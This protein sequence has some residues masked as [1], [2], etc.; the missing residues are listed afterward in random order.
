M[1]VNNYVTRVIEDPAG[2]AQDHW[3]SLL[4]ACNQHGQSAN[5]TL[6]PFVRHAYLAA[7]HSSASAVTQTGWQAYFVSLWDTSQA[8]EQL[9]GVCPM[10]IKAHSYGEYVFDFAWARAY[11][12][13]GLAYYPKAVIAPPFTP[14]PGPRLIAATQANKTALLAA[15][16]A[17]CKDLGVS[18]MH[19]LFID[20][21][22]REACQAHGLLMRQT[23][24]FHWHNTTPGYASFDAFLTTMTQ[25][26]RKKIKQERRKV[27]D[28]GVR[29][30]SKRGLAITEQDWALFYRC[31]EQTY[32]EH[33]N[34]PYLTPAFFE[35]MRDH[36]PENWVMFVAYTDTDQAFACSL[37][38]LEVDGHGQAVAAFGRYWGALAR[39][40]CLH[41]EACYYQPLMWCIENGVQ[42]FEGGAQGE[43][44]MARALMPQTTYSAHWLAHPSFADAVDRYLERETQ[45]MQAYVQDLQA[46]NPFKA[47]QP[48]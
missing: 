12:E 10:Y 6:N 41:F 33:G 1:S 23:V 39:V 44:K 28:A 30:E 34:A 40:D 16:L 13:H 43:H 25:D 9:V 4:T 35:A 3:D 36:M 47:S 17:I 18:S 29:F 11:Q 22:D 45:G 2:I 8:Q 15:T 20:D 26:K 14:V 27:A 32:V 7:M 21:S 42:R 19:A 31:Y 38:G 5:G 24:Q 37:V 46:R 48:L